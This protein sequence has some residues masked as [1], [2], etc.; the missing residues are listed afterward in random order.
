M[1]WHVIT[2]DLLRINA[3][4]HLGNVRSMTGHVFYYG[5]TTNQRIFTSWKR[6]VYDRVCFDVHCHC[7]DMS[8]CSWQ[9]DSGRRAFRPSIPQRKLTIHERKHVRFLTMTQTPEEIIPLRIIA[10]ASLETHVLSHLHFPFS[11]FFSDKRYD[12]ACYY[13][14]FITHMTFIGKTLRLGHGMLLLR[15]YYAYNISRTNAKTR[16]GH[17]ITTDLLRI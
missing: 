8:N 5:F 10:H 11:E 15:I 17:V 16:T 4:L 14:G 9:G 3:F 12:M 7:R 2:T 6:S 1:T 13:Y